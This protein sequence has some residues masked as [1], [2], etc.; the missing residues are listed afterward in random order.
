M[1]QKNKFISNIGFKNTK[2]PPG[3]DPGGVVFGRWRADESLS[4]QKTT[5]LTQQD[6][7]RQITDYR[8]GLSSQNV[9][10]GFL[11]FTLISSQRPITSAGSE[12]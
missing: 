2:T 11:A 10:Q 3:T 7:A 9:T 8:T 4:K 5:D 6:D 1:N 12:P